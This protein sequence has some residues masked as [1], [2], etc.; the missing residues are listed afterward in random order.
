MKC[1]I[2]GLN[3]ATTTDCRCKFC[4]GKPMVFNY[5]GFNVETRDW[6][7]DNE[8]GFLLPKTDIDEKKFYEKAFET[9]L[10]L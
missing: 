5:N 7:E 10:T 3:E 4:I 1:N 6:L 9:K 2:C 8:W